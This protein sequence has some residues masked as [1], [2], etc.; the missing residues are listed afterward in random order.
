[1]EEHKLYELNNDEL[2]KCIEELFDFEE[3][4]EA[5]IILE[6]RDSDKALE[7]GKQIIEFD[8]GDEYLQ[9]TIWDILFYENRK[10]MI[11]AVDRRENTIGKTLLD[12][13]I[14]D[15]T[16]YRTNVSNK[17]LKKIQNTYTSVDFKEK[18][19]MRCNYNKFADM[20]MNV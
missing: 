3:V 17:F 15:L 20:Y 7:L 1:M 16:N 11:N 5:F 6:R 8:K 10:E 4:A 19:G 18:E 9:A 14:I 12:D 2:V 13:I